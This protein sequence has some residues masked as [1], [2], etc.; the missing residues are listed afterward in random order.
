MLNLDIDN[1]T[2]LYLKG[3]SFEDSSFYKNSIVNN[4]ITI[5]ENGKFGECYDFTSI[6]GSMCTSSGVKLPQDVF[7]IEWWEKNTT[8][9]STK[10]SAFVNNIGNATSG[11]NSFAIGKATGSN[12]PKIWLSS[13]GTSWDIA[14]T[15]DIG[16]P[17]LN[18]WV[19]RAVIYN[20]IDINCYEDGKLFKTISLNG[21]TLHILDNELIFKSLRGTTSSYCAYIDEFKMH[22]NVKWDSDFTPPLS[23]Y[24][25]VEDL[26]V[27]ATLFDT[28]NRIKV[29][30]ELKQEEKTLLK[31]NLIE[32]GVECSDNDKM[33]SLID[34][35]R[36]MKSFPSYTAG[37]ENVIINVRPTVPANTTFIN[38][39]CLFYGGIKV[40]GNALNYGTIIF[41]HYRDNNLISTKETTSSITWNDF[42]YEFSNI[43]PFDVLKIK[44]SGQAGIATSNNSSFL[45]SYNN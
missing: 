33:S 15:I 26:E 19:H 43:M 14:Q 18:E 28:V 35:V 42:T 13:N 16:N 38:F 20:G 34:K 29:I 11:S 10:T 7:T 22:N 45:I 2:I 9:T 39:N 17:C 8:N 30:N 27:N 31:N 24:A 4:G 40:K 12:N 1:N 5:N 6:D 21:K 3:D 32:K 41:E 44:T 36:N 25:K 37:D 23:Q